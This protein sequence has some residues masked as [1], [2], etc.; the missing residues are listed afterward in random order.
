MLKFHAFDD[1]LALTFSRKRKLP[2]FVRNQTRFRAKLAERATSQRCES[3]HMLQMTHPHHT[4]FLRLMEYW[5]VL[6]LAGLEL[7]WVRPI[8]N[9]VHTCHFRIV[10]T[11]YFFAVQEVYRFQSF[12]YNT[13]HIHAL[14]LGSVS[15]VL[16]KCIFLSVFLK[17]KH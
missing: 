14:F 2:A 5:K 9:T 4:I 6:Y 16:N 1:K 3:V 17:L 10:F 15:L 7:M 13:L 8:F 11:L 12:R